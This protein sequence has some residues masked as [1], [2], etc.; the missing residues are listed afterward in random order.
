MPENITRPDDF[1]VRLAE[2]IGLP[3]ERLQS[4]TLHSRAGQPTLV[5]ATY[6]VPNRTSLEGHRLTHRF[7]VVD[8]GAKK[9]TEA[10]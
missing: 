2:A 4:Y 9:T 8:I 1:A 3:I 10:A 6:W 5:R 7:V